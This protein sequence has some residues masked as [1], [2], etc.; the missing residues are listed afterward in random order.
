MVN[1]LPSLKKLTNQKRAGSSKTGRH[2][3][4]KEIF[5]ININYSTLHT[6]LI[7]T[8]YKHVCV[9]FFYI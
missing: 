5:S 2:E 8:S 1:S 4:E 9:F 7:Y 3:K 6:I